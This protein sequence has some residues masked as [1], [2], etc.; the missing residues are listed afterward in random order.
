[1]KNKNE[2]VSRKRTV[3]KTSNACQPC[4]LKKKKCDG[5][6]PC[7][8]CTT[9][10]MPNSC[11]YVCKNGQRPTLHKVGLSS[12]LSIEKCLEQLRDVPSK[13]LDEMHNKITQVRHLINDI[14]RLLVLTTDSLNLIPTDKSKSVETD[15]L[16]D[17]CF[18]P[19]RFSGVVKNKISEPIIAKN[20]GLYSPMLPF[21]S[22]GIG[23]I[24]KT[25]LSI[26]HEKGA[27]SAIRLLLKFLDANSTLSEEEKHAHNMSPL[28]AYSYFRELSPPNGEK[29]YDVVL[30]KLLSNNGIQLPHQKMIW[31]SL[32]VI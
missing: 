13:D 28:E 25:L 14:S 20:F 10:S 27:K 21:S 19:T 22:Q 29:L 2:R 1:M 23:W 18:S 5:L 9:D 24:I 7:S 32:C 3:S 17:T 31:K 6:S 26:S 12:V 11:I 30:R 15:F 16:K 8:R 4:K